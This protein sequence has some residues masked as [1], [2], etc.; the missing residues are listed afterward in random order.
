MLIGIFKRNL[1]FNSLMLLPFAA[2]MRLYSL[3]YPSKVP[4]IK[5]GGVLYEWFVG[6]L[7]DSPIIHSIIALFLI[8]FEAV[9]INRLVI[10]NRFSREITLYAGMFFIILTSLVPPMLSL[11][12]Y[13]LGLHFLF[14]SFIY[15]FK[16]YKK[17]KSERYLFN[18]G[19][20]FAVALLI[21]NIFLITI[22]PILLGFL[23]IRS[24]K[25]RELFQ[26]ITG[27]LTPLYFY[28]F[29][30]FWTGNAFEFN[31]LFLHSFIDILS[32]DIS[33]YIV[34][35]VYGFLFLYTIMTYHGFVMKKSIQS[36]KKI[37]IIFWLL[38]ILFIFLF[39]CDTK[40][41]CNYSLLLAFPLSIFTSM[42]FLRIKN[43]LLAE[44][45]SVL[46]VFA[47]LIYHFQFY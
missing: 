7:P 9:M 42:I 38:I 27:I 47:V 5:E 4:V 39:F 15:L 36:Q 20:F 16:T 40:Y 34:I 32:L 37:N 21:H 22:I 13:M 24:F 25:L 41:I 17:F 35:I 1:F 2:I 46:I 8:F 43:N 28:A 29:W 26:I 6:L 14:M 23:S 45:V 11:S 12:P 19:F 3:V 44:I 10:K 31:G 18:V 33:Q 30:A